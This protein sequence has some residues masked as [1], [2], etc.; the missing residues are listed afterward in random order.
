[1][2][3]C[4]I[5]YEDSK[6]PDFYPLT[7]LRPVYFLRPGV[8]YL[9]EKIVDGFEGYKPHLF[10]RREISPV[11]RENTRLSVNRL[12][13]LDSDEFVFVNG[14]IRF[15]KDFADALKRADGSVILTSNEDIVAFKIVGR[16]S[17]EQCKFLEEGELERLLENLKSEAETLKVEIPLY[18]YLWDLVNAIGGEISD[19]FAFFKEQSDDEGFLGSSEELDHQGRLYPGVEFISIEDIYISPDSVLL[20]GVVLDASK[21]PIFVGSGVRIEPHTYIVGPLYIG[22]GTHVVG[23]KISG[24]SI[25][26]ICRVGGE[27]EETIIQGHTNKYHAG[28]IGHS[29]LGEWINLGAMTTNSDLKNNYAN[30]RVS[31]NGES[32]DTECLK[33]GSFI[34]DFTKTA[35]GT[36]LNTGINIGISCNIIAHGLIAERE[37][38][39]F[40]WYSP[41]HKMSYNFAK[42]IGTI[43]RTMA[44]RGVELTEFYKKRLLDISQNSG[45]K[46]R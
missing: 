7:L 31:V 39:S 25:G 45:E 40:T 38:P 10:C 36:L 13:E 42:A 11:L 18:S 28:F 3:K 22:R 23:G 41:K 26:P 1:M 5:I 43:E 27:I 15:N 20:P 35:I 33:V 8:R 32:I 34:G 2:K 44:R 24:C 19:D 14:R 12:D 9:F 30:V 29:Y 6:S 4:L 17:E 21:G 16:L 46:A 37:I